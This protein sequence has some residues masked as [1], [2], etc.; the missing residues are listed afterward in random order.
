MAAEPYVPA[1]AYVNVTSGVVSGLVVLATFINRAAS[2]SDV[3]TSP[4]AAA[5]ATASGRAR[6][7]ACQPYPY[8][9]VLPSETETASV[10]GVRVPFF[11]A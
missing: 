10:L 3:D 4:S 11:V 5:Y 9:P 6:R 7:G 2:P 1:T 8:T